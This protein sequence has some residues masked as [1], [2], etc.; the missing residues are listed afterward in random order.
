MGERILDAKC[1]KAL[2]DAPVHFSTHDPLARWLG[3]DS[4][5]DH[6]RGIGESIDAKHFQRLDDQAA[7]WGS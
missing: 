7:Y 3:L 2:L 6:Y 1:L 4:R 5:P